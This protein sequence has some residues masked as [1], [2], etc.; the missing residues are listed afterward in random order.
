[1][2][3]ISAELG[4]NGSRSVRHFGPASSGAPVL[5]TIWAEGGLSSTCTFAYRPGCWLGM[6]SST[7][8]CVQKVRHSSIELLFQTSDSV[9]RCITPRLRNPSR[10]CGRPFDRCSTSQIQLYKTPYLDGRHSHPL[11]Y[12]DA[13]S[14]TL[15]NCF[16]LVPGT[17]TSRSVK[18]LPP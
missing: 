15:R 12:P 1:M 2:T 7:R 17:D 4:G 9:N 5:V 8:A 10:V 13:V 14:D 6:S 16:S 11:T 18:S 3:A